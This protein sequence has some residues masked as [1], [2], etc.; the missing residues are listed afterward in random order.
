MSK[1][2][3]PELKF[4][5]PTN[6]HYVWWSKARVHLGADPETARARYPA[7]RD[8]TTGSGRARRT[9]CGV[10]G[11]HDRVG[12]GHGPAP[13]PA[14]HCDWCPKCGEHHILVVHEIVVE[15]RADVEHVR[16]LNARIG[17]P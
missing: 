2:R 8:T 13:L 7:G 11:R 3:V 14:P 17:P 1:V 9:R 16:A 5:K 10:R 15:T 12:P 4:H 6:Q